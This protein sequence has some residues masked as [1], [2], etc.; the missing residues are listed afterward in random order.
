MFVTFLAQGKVKASYYPNMNEVTSVEGI[1]SRSDYPDS[2]TSEGWLDNLDSN[3]NIGDQY[4]LRMQTIFL[5]PQTGEYIFIGSF[6]EYGKVYLSTSANPADKQEILHVD[7]ALSQHY[8]SRFV[9]LNSV[10]RQSFQSRLCGCTFFG[11]A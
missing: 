2:P 11:R 5:A 1:F 8:W 10:S 9:S 7:R 3:I 6:D 4:V